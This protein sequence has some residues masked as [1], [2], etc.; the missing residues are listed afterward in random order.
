VLR[1][2]NNNYYDLAEEDLIEAEDRFTVGRYNKCAHWCQQAGEKYLKYVLVN[3]LGIKDDDAVMDHNL[4]R[5]LDRINRDKKILT[6]PAAALFALTN[7]YTKARY[8]G[9][10]FV[11][12]DKTT[13]SE[14]LEHAQTIKDIV[15]KYLESFPIEDVL[16][17]LVDRFPGKGVDSTSPD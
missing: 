2:M 13:A 3:K 16:K 15:D 11:E 5:I 7:Y 8:P 4:K 14:L 17:T 9:E 1:C 10:G 6:I 12:V